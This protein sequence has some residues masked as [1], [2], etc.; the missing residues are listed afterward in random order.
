MKYF[1]DTNTCI[2]FLKGMYPSISKHLLSLSPDDVK[3]PSMVK[4][5][6]LFGACKSIQREHNFDKV[7]TFLKPFEIMPFSS[8]EAATYAEIRCAVESGGKP[9]G[10]NDLVIAAIVMSY[11]GI[12]V[13]HNIREFSHIT[14]LGLADWVE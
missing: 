10:P 8:I 6:L 14:G 12:L 11:G 4:A 3:I 7:E 9:V 13:T 2:Y 5:E 1:L